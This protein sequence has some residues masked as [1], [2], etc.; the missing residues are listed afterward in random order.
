MAMIDLAPTLLE[1][2]NTDDGAALWTSCGA[3]ALT[4]R[5]SGPPLSGPRGVAPSM[6]ALADRLRML[7]AH[8]G[9]EVHV[10][11]PALLSERAA[12]TGHRRQGTTSCGGAS[13][14]VEAS[15]GWVAVSLARDED[16]AA[17][18]AWLEADLDPSDLVA[19]EREVRCHPVAELVERA[20]LLGIPCSGLGEVTTPRLPAHRL[21]DASQPASLA[22]L[23]VVDLSSLWAGPLCGRLLASAGARV[24]KVESTTRPDG[25]RRGPREFFEL[26]NAGKE[27]VMLDLSGADGRSELRRMI[28]S[29]DV[30]IE[31]SRP[32]ALQQMGIDAAEFRGRVWLSIT[33]HGRDQPLRVGFGDDAAVAGGLVA[34]D[35]QGP[36]FAADA[37][38]DP[39][40]GL[41]GAVA[42]LDRLASGGRWLI[43]LAL[44]HAAA[45]ATNPPAPR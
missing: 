4:G 5:R 10:D 43:D 34:Y 6:R 23:L 13:R 17:V 26:M 24:L 33:S 45:L 9:N 18:P 27:S 35:E 15:D 8:L 21:G 37:A 44:S 30:V 31:A 3:A 12:I 29:A 32:R 25:A 36:V 40:T 16:V 22:G 20:S 38:A 41:I 42:V 1:N 14:L 28:D 7:T 39:I 11:G 19:I 2:V